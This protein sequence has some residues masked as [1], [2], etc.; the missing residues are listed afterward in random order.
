MVESQLPVHLFFDSHISKRPEF[1]RDGVTIN[2]VTGDDRGCD[3][4]VNL[5]FSLVRFVYLQ[6]LGFEIIDYFFKGI[7]GYKVWG[8]V[9]P[10][11]GP[12]KGIFAYIDLD[13]NEIETR[14]SSG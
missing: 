2:T 9:R 11:Q 12:S 8:N 4:F 14:R 1:Y 13:Q 3:N 6:Q 10:K 7:T 5:S